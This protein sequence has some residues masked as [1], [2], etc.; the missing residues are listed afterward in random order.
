MVAPLF[1]VHTRF[2]Y[3]HFEWN[4]MICS[5][6][7]QTFEMFTVYHPQFIHQIWIN[8]SIFFFSSSSQT[9]MEFPFIFI[10]SCLPY[11]F[12][13][14]FSHFYPTA[15][16]GEFVYVQSTLTVQG[17]GKKVQSEQEFKYLNWEK[18]KCI[19]H[20]QLCNMQTHT[21]S[22]SIFHIINVRVR[23]MA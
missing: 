23:W 13:I 2:H 3:C 5:R 8:F 12:V 19:V 10:F 22:H 15:A 11:S 21:R 18:M 14:W 1:T 9:G 6:L 4:P 16:G 17:N 20:F 7:R